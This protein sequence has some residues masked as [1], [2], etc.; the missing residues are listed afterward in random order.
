MEELSFFIFGAG[1]C[2]RAFARR[3]SA[4]C[5]GTTR[6]QESFDLLRQNHIEPLLFDDCHNETAMKKALHKTTHLIISIPPDDTGD[7]VLQK[8]LLL[9]DMPQLQWIGYL[10]TIGVYGDHQ[11]AWVD[12]NTLPRPSLLRNQRRLKAEQDWQKFADEANV[13]LAVLR[14]SGIYGPGRNAFI[15]LIK[16][17]AHRIIKPGLNFNRIHVDDITGVLQFF[18]DKKLSGTF[19]V[20]DDKPAPPQDVVA[21]AA[22]LM[23]IV[24]PPEIPFEKAELTPIMRSF[25]ADNKQVTNEKLKHKGYHFHYPDYESALDDMWRTNNWR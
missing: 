7:P 11:G 2:A 14:L 23:G 17:N 19:N 12:E 6:Q 20:S 10:S 22:Q 3:S 18:A 24:P 25:Y 13:P 1:F 8:P 9:K 5:Y 21:Y 15:K 4:F 16:K